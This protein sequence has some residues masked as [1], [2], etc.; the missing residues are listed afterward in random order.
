MLSR[1]S[2]LEALVVQIA[3]VDARI[4]RLAGELADTNSA[5][6]SLEE[7][8]SALLVLNVSRLSLNQCAMLKTEGKLPPRR[9]RGS[10]PIGPSQG[11]VVP[12]SYARMG[13]EPPTAA[14]PAA[15]SIPLMKSRR[16]TLSFPFFGVMGDRPPWR[17]ALWNHY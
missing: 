2:E 6:R 15:I 11:K 14:A 12:P 9:A 17:H 16:S 1:R 5:A 4:D 3:D 7:E 10:L 13:K 8:I